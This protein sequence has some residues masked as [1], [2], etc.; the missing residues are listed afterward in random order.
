MHV[1][2]EI[3]RSIIDKFPEMLDILKEYYQT[4]KEINLALKALT[5]TDSELIEGPSLTV[6]GGYDVDVSSIT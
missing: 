6:E 5:I 3:E 4:E 2:Q 1:S